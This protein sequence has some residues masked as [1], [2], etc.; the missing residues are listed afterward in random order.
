MYCFARVEA[1]LDEAF[2]ECAFADCGLSEEDDLVLDVAE[3][4]ALV[5]HAANPNNNTVA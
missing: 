4:G 1:A 2:N 5:E 3:T